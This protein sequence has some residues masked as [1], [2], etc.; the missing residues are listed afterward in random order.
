M[1]SQK[2][3]HMRLAKLIKQKKKEMKLNLLFLFFSKESKTNGPPVA[4]VVD[5]D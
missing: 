4:V 3:A 5:D 2:M 1:Q